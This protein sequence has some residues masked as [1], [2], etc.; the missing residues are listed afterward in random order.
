MVLIARWSQLAH[1]NC[2]KT[3]SDLRLVKYIILKCTLT[4]EILGY[5]KPISKFAPL[6]LQIRSVCF[7]IS[8]NVLEKC[9]LLG[10]YMHFSDLTLELRVIGSYQPGY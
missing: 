9:Q 1:G 6:F 10:Q 3:A 5:V 4:K 8:K 2:A 7:I